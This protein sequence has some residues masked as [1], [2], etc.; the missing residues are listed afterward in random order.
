MTKTKNTAIARL[1]KLLAKIRADEGC[2]YAESEK[3]ERDFRSIAETLKGLGVKLRLTDE[4]KGLRRDGPAA[5]VAEVQRR[6]LADE[7]HIESW[8][9]T[10]IG[11]WDIYASNVSVMYD[12]MDDPWPGEVLDWLDPSGGG[13]AGFPG[14][15][16]EAEALLEIEETQSSEDV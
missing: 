13:L 3:A 12:A 6:L 1:R 15:Y 2:A 8:G 5:V 4:V 14:T 10:L 9:G 11:Q 16:R 7:E